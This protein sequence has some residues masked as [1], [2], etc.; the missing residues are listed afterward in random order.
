MARSERNF[1]YLAGLLKSREREL[2][3]ESLARELLSARNMADVVAA[4]PP[5]RFAQVVGVDPTDSGIERAAAE[6]LE[7]LWKVV[8]D[9]APVA[10]LVQLVAAPLDV[11]NLKVALLGHLRG[12]PSE[13]LYQPTALVTADVLTEVGELSTS[14]VPAHY[15]PVIR[16]GLTA[17]YQTDRSPQALELAMDRARS[18][19]L[20]EIAA[21]RSPA[22][23]AVLSDWGDLSVAET[24]MR[25]KEAGLPWSVVR[26]GSHGISGQVQLQDLFDSPVT[27][28]AQMHIFARPLVTA[29]VQALGRGDD[30]RETIAHLQAEL[31]SRL[32]AHRYAP[33]SIEYAYYFVRRKLCD[34]ANFRIVCLG[35]LRELSAE[36]QA[37]RLSVGFG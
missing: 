16:V 14:R 22:L 2:G 32:G 30:M 21:K 27:E 28:W 35:T 29:A 12:E 19:L 6:E 3:D 18:L 8:A 11:H 23:T 9:Y 36:V 34:L 7:A 26:W 20:V 1:N 25:G 24:I 31:T 37:E 33:P 4:L 5:I 13:N 15:L 10:E 17:Y